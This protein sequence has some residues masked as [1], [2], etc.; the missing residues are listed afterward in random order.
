MT[1]NTIAKR[2]EFVKD[3]L[4]LPELI[5]PGFLPLVLDLPL[6]PVQPNILSLTG[7]K[8]GA[9]QSV[10]TDCTAAISGQKRIE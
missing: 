2:D 5:G 9:G 8:Y 6:S 4:D 3:F 10:S 1:E 7:S